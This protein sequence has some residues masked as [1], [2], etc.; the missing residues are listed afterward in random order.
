MHFTWNPA[1][2]NHNVSIRNRLHQQFTIRRGKQMSWTPS[3]L[4]VLFSMYVLPKSFENKIKLTHTYRW[5]KNKSQRNHI[6]KL[7]NYVRFILIVDRF[8]LQKWAL[9]DGIQA[10]PTGTFS[11][12]S[13][14]FS[15]YF[16]YFIPR[17]LTFISDRTQNYVAYDSVFFANVFSFFLL[18]YYFLRSL[19]VKSNHVYHAWLFL[20]ILFP[21]MCTYI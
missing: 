16:L 9:I 18:S 15:L 2:V 8:F 10:L 13:S 7:Y 21:R 1:W 11:S 19:N 6:S 5:R 12:F 3:W 4:F 20:V 14:L 17:Q